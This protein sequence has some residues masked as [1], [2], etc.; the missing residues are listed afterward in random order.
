MVNMVKEED[1]VGVA[2][3]KATLSALLER[4]ARG[5]RVVVA[6]RGRPVAVLAPPD[7]VRETTPSHRGLASLAG[8]MTDWPDMERDVADVVRRRRSALDREAPDLG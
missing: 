4:V 6:K 1:V 5:G 2:E 7:A 3:A 8:V